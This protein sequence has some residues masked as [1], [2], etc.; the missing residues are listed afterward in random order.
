MGRPSK[1]P[2][3]FRRDALELVR[4][5]G[6]S[7]ADVALNRPGFDDCSCY[8]VTASRAIGI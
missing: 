5:S 2:E 8:W 1:Y 6:R 3:K 7:L 4:T